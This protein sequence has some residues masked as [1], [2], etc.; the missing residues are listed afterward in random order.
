MWITAASANCDTHTHKKKTQ[1][2]YEMKNSSGLFFKMME[3]SL[4]NIEI[5]L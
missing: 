1:E 5:I 4:V 3:T 2:S